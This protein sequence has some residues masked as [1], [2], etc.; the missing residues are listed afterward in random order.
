MGGT[1]VSVAAMCDGTLSEPRLTATELGGSDRLVDQ[2]AQLVEREA[3]RAGGDIDGVGVGIPSAIEWQTGRVHSSVNIPLKDV[4]LRQVLHERLGL[5]VFVDN[6][7]NCAALAEAHDESGWPVVDHLVMLTVGTGVG[8]G[9]VIDRRIYRGATGA[10]GEIGHM[11]IGLSFDGDPL[12]LDGEDGFPR[13]GS[14]ERLA[15]GRALDRLGEDAARRHPESAL[16]RG[17]RGQ[18]V[19]GPEVVRA[20]QEGDATARETLA[21]LGRRLGVGIANVVNVFDPDVVAVGGGVSAAGELLMGPARETALRFILPGVGTR[22]EIRL[23]R[24]GPQA[25]VRGAAL[26]AGQELRHQVSQGDDM[27]RRRT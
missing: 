25:G 3:E 7:A 1:K 12:R 27:D 20:A 19:A 11:I 16:A 6:D 23:A 18:A 5:P 26:L 17:A 22:T 2:L 15:A 10:A 13:P 21:E 9:I 8:G 4:P 14:L 24:A